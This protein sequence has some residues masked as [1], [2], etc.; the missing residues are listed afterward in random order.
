MQLNNNTGCVKNSRGD[1]QKTQLCEHL[2]KLIQVKI[3]LIQEVTEINVS[4]R[5]GIMLI[6][7]E[8]PCC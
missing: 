3:K 8:L 4:N 6:A 5:S 2:K 1:R 7:A